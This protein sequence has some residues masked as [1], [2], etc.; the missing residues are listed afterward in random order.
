LGLRYVKANQWQT[1]RVDLVRR[2]VYTFADARLKEIQEEAYAAARAA[3]D[4]AWEREGATLIESY[5]M[6]QPPSWAT[7]SEHTGPIEKATGRRR[8]ATAAR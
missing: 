2:Y 5:A 6:P 7:Q 3:S 4:E 8:P 1:R